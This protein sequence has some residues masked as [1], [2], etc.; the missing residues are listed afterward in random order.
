MNP[1]TTPRRTPLLASE[2]THSA[3]RIVRMLDRRAVA[4]ALEA[5]PFRAVARPTFVCLPSKGRHGS[6]SHRQ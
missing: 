1:A 6:A 3:V 4:V 2:G 5:A